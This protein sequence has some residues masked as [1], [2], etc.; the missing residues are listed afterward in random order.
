MDDIRC[1]FDLNFLTLLVL[2]DF[3]KAFDSV[4]HELLLQKVGDYFGFSK[5]ALRLL[6]NYLSNRV[7][8]VKIADKRSA[9]RVVKSGVPQ[10]SVLGPI[11][12]AAFIN[13]IFSVT[14]NVSMHAYADDIQVYM[15]RRPGLI[16]DLCCRLNE[17]L[18]RINEWARNNRL[19]LN[20][21]KSCVLPIANFPV[22]QSCL[23]QIKLGNTQLS[24]VNKAK[25]LGFV[26]NSSLS[27]KDHINSVVGKIYFVLRNL[28]LTSEFMPS[29]TKAHLVKQLILPI[30]NYGATVYS[31]LDSSSMHKLEV[32]FNFATRYV[33]NLRRYDHI[34]PWKT[35]ILGCSL[36]N[37]L[38]VRNCIFLHRIFYFKIPSYLVEKLRP[39]LSIRCTTF[40]VPQFKFLNSERC[41]FINAIRLWNSLDQR[42]RSECNVG[43]FKRLVTE[44]FS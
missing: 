32:V 44:F 23:P 12:F 38:R 22:V 24:I 34:S 20:P 17:D 7:Q 16:E 42:I 41:F 19:K 15:S 11:L 27:C 28:R 37:Y 35:K 25:N 29:E 6:S 5:H 1:S 40:I 30:I 26:L 8:C 3:S 2:L 9:F 36:E 39:S 13:D 31:K 33:F 10:G 43:K 4:D 14:E 18:S 21:D